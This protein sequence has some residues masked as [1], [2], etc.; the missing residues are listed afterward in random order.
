MKH[1]TMPYHFQN[2]ENHSLYPYC[3]LFTLVYYF[4][5]DERERESDKKEEEVEEEEERN[6]EN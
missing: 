3:T 6:I 1:S 2:K 5:L 4:T